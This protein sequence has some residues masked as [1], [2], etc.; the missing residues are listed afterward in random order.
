M[1]SRINFLIV[2][3]FWLAI[4]LGCNFSV[5]TANLDEIKFDKDE[6]GSNSKTK[7]EQNDEIVA[8]SNVNNAVGTNT[9]QFRLLFDNVEG[10]KSGTVAYKIQGEHKND[11]S[12]KVFFTFSVPS[13]FVPGTYKCEMVLKGEDGKELDRKTANFTIVE[14]S[15]AKTNKTK[16]TSA[17]DTEESDEDK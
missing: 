1:K 3:S 6:S 14:N 9:V 10:A 17:N 16:K 12:R 15:S 4:S 5:G 11:G 8:I 13:G 2:F 7:F